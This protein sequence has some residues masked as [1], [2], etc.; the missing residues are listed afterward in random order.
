MYTTQRESY[1]DLLQHVERRSSRPVDAIVVAAGRPTRSLA[2]AIEL[3]ARL[4]ANLVTVCSGQVRPETIAALAREWPSLQCHAV[5]L[6][7]N[8]NHP[9]LAFASSRLAEVQD[10]R[11]G[12]LNTKRNI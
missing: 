12:L 10:E 4:G 11:H 1:P 8:Y 3:A 7:D 6:P 5:Y 9:L 2:P